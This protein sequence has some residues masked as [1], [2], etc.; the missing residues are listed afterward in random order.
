MVFAVP[1]AVVENAVEA[2]K[3]VVGQFGAESGT[4]K[5]IMYNVRLPKGQNPGVRNK[6]SIQVYLFSSSLGAV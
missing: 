5:E 6:K 2:S 1:N 4:S 3:D